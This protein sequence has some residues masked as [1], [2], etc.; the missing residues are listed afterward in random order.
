MSKREKSWH[1]SKKFI[2]WVLSDITWKS[3]LITILLVYR[4]DLTQNGASVWWLLLAIVI[5]AGFIEI[6]FILGQAALDKYVRLAE[7]AAEQFKNNEND[8]TDPKVKQ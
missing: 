6:G 4:N 3:I 7:I 1:E 8:H 5:T 2:A